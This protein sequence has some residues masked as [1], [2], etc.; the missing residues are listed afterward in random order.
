MPTTHTSLEHHFVFSTKDR[1]PFL[2][3]AIR[4]RVHEYL[5]GCLRTEGAAPLTIGG[6]EDHVHIL[7]GLRPTHAVASV[8]REVKRVSSKW[9][10]EEMGVPRFAWQEGYGAFAVSRSNVTAVA[11]YIE[12][13]EE[14][15]RKRT[16]QDEYKRLLARHGIEFDVRYLW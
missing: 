10:H 7:A 8:M 6:V 11:K 4:D 9:M 2:G 1:F 16:F 5:G 12:T 13:Q 15:H 3:P 14:H